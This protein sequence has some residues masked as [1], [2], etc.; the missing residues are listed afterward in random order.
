MLSNEKGLQESREAQEAKN[1]KEELRRQ[2]LAGQQAAQQATQVPAQTQQEEGG[3]EDTP[4]K[5]G[6]KKSK[7]ATIAERRPKQKSIHFTHEDAIEIE[8]LKLQLIRAGVPSQDA[9][10]ENIIYFFFRHCIELFK[11]GIPVE[12]FTNSII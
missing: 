7:A 1:R 8:H 10:A 9:N 3:A 6:R 11:D 2:M 4:S 12:E 5:R